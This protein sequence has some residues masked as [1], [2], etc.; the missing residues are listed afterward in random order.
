M[1]INDFRLGRLPTHATTLQ[2]VG[3]L[4]TL[5]IFHPKGYL[6]V[7]FA[8][9]GCLVVFSVLRS[10]L[11]VFSTLRVCLG[12]IFGTVGNVALF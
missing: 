10:C 12:R 4:S 8:L 9:R 7:F 11:A 1:E 3:I 6:V 2:E 5:F